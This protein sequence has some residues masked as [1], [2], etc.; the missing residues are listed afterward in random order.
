[1]LAFAGLSVVFFIRYLFAGLRFWGWLFPV[2]LF[3]ALAG[4]IWLAT[5]HKY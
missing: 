2:S 1:M 5:S 3:A 4:M